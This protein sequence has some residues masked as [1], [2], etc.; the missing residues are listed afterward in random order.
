MMNIYV[1]VFV[2]F[3]RKE[4]NGVQWCAKSENIVNRNSHIYIHISYKLKYP[5]K[6]RYVPTYLWSDEMIDVN[7]MIVHTIW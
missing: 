5:S 1:P 7:A 3:S 2:V 6:I 4:K